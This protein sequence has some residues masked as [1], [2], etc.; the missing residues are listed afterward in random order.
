MA[1]I[2]LENRRPPAVISSSELV[3]ITIGL[4]CIDT[5]MLILA[6]EKNPRSPGDINNV[7]TWCKLTVLRDRSWY[8]YSS[9][10]IIF[11]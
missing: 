11:I 10:K 8:E 7:Y 1:G 2:W 5:R 6:R 9:D 4:Y 3:P